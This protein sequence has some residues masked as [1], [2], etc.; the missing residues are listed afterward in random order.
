MADSFDAQEIHQEVADP[1]QDAPD[2]EPPRSGSEVIDASAILWLNIVGSQLGPW[3][4]VSNQPEARRAR[5]R[6]QLVEILK[7]RVDLAPG[8]T[9][10]LEVNQYRTDDLGDYMGLWSHA[11]VTQGTELVA[12]IEGAATGPH[13]MLTDEHCRILVEA[14]QVLDD[15]R[16]A[17]VI[18]N[19]KPD[20]NTILTAASNSVERF[21]AVFARYVWAKIKDSVMS[22]QSMLDSYLRLV[23][24]PKTR[25][26]AR[27]AYLTA[28]YEDLGMMSRPPRESEIKLAQSMCRLLLL[29]EAEALQ[30]T[31]AG[32]LLPNLVRADAKKPKYTAAEILGPAR[33]DRARISAV[34][35]SLIEQEERARTLLTWL[36]N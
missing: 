19:R 36:A 32:V 21:G 23:E 35:A 7:G 13:E 27:D 29:P 5:L 20:P 25:I 18:D 28:L 1:D 14:R 26:E 17:I 24:N 3:G 10:D 9:F 11:P 16:A 33:L 12:F 6:L 15:T 8:Q 4:P 30:P 22:S 31:I 34:A 2:S